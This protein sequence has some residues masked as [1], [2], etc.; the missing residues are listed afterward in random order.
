MHKALYRVYRPKNFSDVIGQEHIVRTL[1]NQIE[2]NNV[3]HAYLFCGT[4]GTGKTSTAKIFSRAVNCTNLHNDEPCNECENCR[5]IL[6]DKTMDVVEI[7]AASNNSVD[8][9][10]ELR[11]N[12]KYSPAKAKYKVYIIDEVHMLSQGAF[13]ALLKTLEEPPSYVIFILA[14]TEPHKIPATILS[15]CQRFDF[16]RVTVKDISSRMRYICEKEGIEADEKALNLIAR[17]SQGALRDALSILDQCISF[18]GNKISYNDVIELLGSVNIEQLFDLAESIIKEDTRK[19]LQI[20]NDFIIW[21]KDV[22][23]LVNDLID[24]FRNLMVCK[25]SNDLD[26]IISLPEETI[27]L[28]KQQAETIDTNNLIRILNILSETQDGMK[29][30]SN[31][32]VLMEVTMMK[33]A[34]PMFDESKE[35][36]IKRIENLEQK[37]ESGNIKVN[38]ISTNQT[39]DNFNENNQ[40]NNNTVEKQEDENIEYENL[41]GDDIKLVEKSWKKILQKMK[42]DKNQVIRA[43][44]QDVDSFN[45]SEDTLY[46]IFT[47]NY[48][49]AK[50][51]LDSPATIQY[52]EKVIREVLN[53]SFSVKI[54]LKSQLSNLN[55]QIKK[56]DKG[57]QILKNIVS[58]DILEVKDSI[59]KR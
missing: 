12:V 2:N 34:Q 36:L 13:N 53:R 49:F 25:I 41:K 56:E 9:I 28:L 46:I 44:L 21:G 32:R 54:A 45:I 14:T 3:G 11:E 42:E 55:T 52:V 6:E 17:N 19:S 24:H 15:R 51:R 16:K 26:E 7:D 23:N 18:E 38:H 8:D 20:L 5:E 47:D 33:I 50:S 37:I 27:D 57:E 4:R 43:L 59:E 39:V 29:I 10:R 40:Q 58:E 22:R 31:P 30:S 1:K 35:A 48:S